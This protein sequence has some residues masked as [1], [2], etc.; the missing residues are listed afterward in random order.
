MM[1]WQLALPVLAAL[2]IQSQGGRILLVSVP[3]RSHV[4]YLAIA[5]RAMVE[6]GHEVH[7]LMPIPPG[8]NSKDF[9]NLIGP[10][11]TIH[12]LSEGRE[13]QFHDEEAMV[14]K[15][16]LITYYS[17]KF[18]IPNSFMFRAMGVMIGSL[19][20]TILGD[21]AL[22]AKFQ[23]LEFDIAMIDGFPGLRCQYVL[24]HRLGIPYVSLT[25]QYEPWQF[26]IPALPSFVPLALEHDFSEQMSFIQRVRNFLSFIEWQTIPLVMA[27]SGWYTTTYAP[28]KPYKSPTQLAAESSIWFINTDIAIDYPRPSLPHVIEVGGLTTKAPSKPL[29][30]DFQTFMDNSGDDGVI[31]VSFGSTPGFPD[32]VEKLIHDTVLKLN[33]HVI[34]KTSQHNLTGPTVITNKWIPQ[35]EILAHP[36]IKLFVT[37]GGNNGQFESLYHAV[38][39]VVIPLFGDQFYNSQRIQYKGYGVVKEAFG[40][41]VDELLE[42]IN[43]V[44]NNAIYKENI[45]KG[46][47]VY[48]SHSMNPRERIVYWMEHVMEFGAGHLHSYS[49]V[50]PWYQYWMIDILIF[51]FVCFLSTVL[52]IY[53]LFRFFC[54]KKSK[55]IKVE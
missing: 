5:G 20:D 3:G 40:T 9:S 48:K 1:M 43:E 36:K 21:E 25:T 13:D 18:K 49:L 4:H 29:P 12:K 52:A 33:R 34:W 54:N 14:E 41:T 27:N 7:I 31:L 30:K 28:D 35:N 2:I 55:N 45:E 32:Q 23:K 47:K 37:H 38:P 19:C 46:S 50:M 24:L 16:N 42:A 8:E 11:I 22:F 39:M 17:H 51:L 53:K 10:S 26:G 44:A 6:R 15:F